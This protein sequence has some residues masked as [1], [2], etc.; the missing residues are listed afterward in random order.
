MVP[1]TRVGLILLV[2]LSTI[3]NAAHAELD[4]VLIGRWDGTLRD[5]KFW[6]SPRTQ[7]RILVIK[8]L[9]RQEQQWVGEGLYGSPGSDLQAITLTVF[10]NGGAVTIQFINDYSSKYRLVLMNN[11][12]LVGTLTS[13]GDTGRDLRFEKTALP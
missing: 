6:R 9:T 12:S 11:T 10:D 4:E 2:L 5:S 7:D 8:S 13:I 1:R 3:P